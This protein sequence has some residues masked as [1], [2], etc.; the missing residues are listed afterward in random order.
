MKTVVCGFEAC[1]LQ[2]AFE[3]RR[4]TAQ[5]VERV[6]AIHCQ[7]RRHVTVAV[8]VESHVD[9]AKFG[10]VKP[11]FETVLACKRLAGNLYGDSGQRNSRRLW[12]GL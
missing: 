7:A 12:A 4:I 1:I 9:A 8:D 5:Q 3:A 11:D 10:W 2:G 6:R